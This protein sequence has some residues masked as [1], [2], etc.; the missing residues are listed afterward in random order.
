MR[1]R[2]VRVH[3]LKGVDLDL[4][5]DELIVFTGVSGSGKSS[6]AFDTLYAEGQR[7]YVE[8]FS[9][10]ARQFL[11]TLDKPEADR[12]ENL[13]PAI[14]VSQRQ[15]RRS[16]RSTVGSVTEVDDYLAVLYARLGRVMCMKCGT[17]VRPA[18]AGSVV[19]AIE[20]LPGGTRYQIGFPM[21]VRPETDRDALAAML[22][23]EGFLRVRAGD[24]VETI[25]E[26]PIPSPADG[27][28]AI[29]VIVD[30]LVRG[31]EDP[32][33]RGDSI[34]TAFDRGLGRCRL[35]TDEHTLTFYRGWRC[36]SCGTEHLAP[37]PRLFRSNSPIGACPSCKG[38]GRVIDLDMDRIVPDPS[39]S[40]EGGAIAPWTT[41]K[42]REHL[43][44]LVRVAPALGIPTDRPFKFLEPE[45]V[46]A[47]VEGAPRQGFLGLRR[48]FA[49]LERKIYKMHVRV[50]LSRW[51]G[52][53]TCPDC[54]GARLRPEALAVKV[55]GRNI[56][57]L[58]ALPIGEARA[59][60][61]A[62]AASEA[63]AG[64]VARRA[65]DPVLARLGYLGRIG[66]D[67]LTLD[68][69]AR[70]L[71]GGEARR[72]ALT[73]ALGSGL[74]N[75][76]YVLDEPSIG[77]H[78]SDIDRLAAA[79]L[80]L[81]DR[82]NAVVVVE[83]DEAIMRAADR[84]VDV[85][86]GAGS[87]GGRI[88]YDGPPEGVALAPESATGAFLSRRRRVVPPA[89]RRPPSGE[90]LTLKGASGHNL[91]DVDVSFPLGLIC[92]VTGVSGSGKSTL[93][94][95]TLYPALLRRLKGGHEP[96]EPHRE[97]LGT[98]AIDDV[99]LVDQS[100]IGRSARSNPVTYLKAFDEIRRAFAGTHEARL[101]DYGPSR[102]SFNVSGGRCEACEG[103]GYQIIDMQFLTD[104]MVRCPE[105]RGTRF[106]AETLEVTYRGKNIA[107]VLDLTVREAFAFFKNRPKVQE[108]LRPLME[109][110][111]DYLR[112]GQP[113]ST[114][115]G[116]EAQRLK[117]AS[118]LPTSGASATRKSA[119]PATLF[120]LDEPTTGLHPSDVLTLIDCLNT[121]ADLGH[122]LI[123]VEHNPELMLCA[124]WIIDLGPGA[125]SDGGRV[126]AEGP[127][128][129]VARAD[130]PT[131][132]VLAAAFAAT[133]ATPDR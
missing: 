33:R 91:K 117:L 105:C 52:Y 131:G 36:A 128:E 9:P 34:E 18:D 90:T 109:V 63:A 66:L 102:F 124:D 121:L 54:Q 108:K 84:L 89:R 55:A 82:G 119:R 29:D 120:L 3:N 60:L 100:P 88:L 67:Y 15:G 75:T 74:V 94:D 132:R 129:E 112:L 113:A 85:G 31:R 98:G 47:I 107:E 115:S 4:P 13:P 126:V 81:R 22:R 59:V 14:A 106:R 72:V 61:D 44:D 6:L 64:Q 114:L 130:T 123:V 104:V 19:A 80:D 97:L 25:E 62:F 41:P 86:P 78:P 50:F 16:S 20:A 24:R 11:E 46:R 38:F 8:T 12:I 125:G 96:A 5:R 37:E 79:L 40:I 26:G 56:A 77:L 57:E 70:T 1:L 49:W 92:V 87:A 71:S 2:G 53:R 42:Y 69:Q 133:G 95:Q 43:D 58:A 23:E 101:R 111:L 73:R 32:G 28:T 39:K 35:I 51:R 118:Y 27:E 93:V 68:R 10:Y 83:H 21:E 103:N 65:I 7:R 116:G 17:E 45:Q 122:S 76:L 110:G 48:F 127:P 99:V 30:R